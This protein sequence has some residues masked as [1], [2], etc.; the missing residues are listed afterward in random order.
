MGW[1]Q[2]RQALLVIHYT[3][4]KILTFS[5]FPK[6]FIPFSIN[7]SMRVLALHDDS[8]VDPALR[9]SGCRRKINADTQTVSCFISVHIFM[10]RNI[11]KETE[12]QSIDLYK[13]I[14]GPFAWPCAPCV[15][16]F[17]LR[18]NRMVSTAR[19]IINSVH[20]GACCCCFPLRYHCFGLTC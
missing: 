13:I 1:N 10:C 3:T 15:S 2:I 17:H 19:P 18:T 9:F 8:L 16:R 20:T 12:V 11:K 4:S 6:S 14:M 5:H 7:P